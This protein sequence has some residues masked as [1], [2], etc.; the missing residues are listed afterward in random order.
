MNITKDSAGSA[1]QKH[2]LS[3]GFSI[4]KIDEVNDMG[5]ATYEFPQY[6]RDDGVK[7]TGGYWSYN[8]ENANGDVL[9]HGWWNS[10]KE[11]DET[12][13]HIDY[14]AKYQPHISRFDELQKKYDELHSAVK[15]YMSKDLSVNALW[16]KMHFGMMSDQDRELL[17]KQMPDNTDIIE[18]PFGNIQIFRSPIF[19]KGDE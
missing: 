11:F 1:S 5:Q 13:E 14:L 6:K 2:I 16:F 12:I 8:V 18:T 17:N 4:F 15:E 3:K 9:F 19:T 10:D 7:I